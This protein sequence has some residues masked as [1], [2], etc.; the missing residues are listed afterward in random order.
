MAED[1]M[2]LREATYVALQQGGVELLNAP[3]RFMGTVLDL[4]DDGSVGARV[5]EQTCDAE[6]LAPYVEAARVRTPE[7]LD[8]AI[9]RASHVLTSDRFIQPD[10]AE[11][12]ANDLAWGLARYLGMAPTTRMQWEVVPAR[13]VEA[14]VRS[15]PVHAGTKYA[16]DPSAVRVTQTSTQ[17]VPHPAVSGA[18]AP[19]GVVPGTGWTSAPG[20]A[21]QYP[22]Q[23]AQA[24]PQPLTPQSD[25][26]EIIREAER[27]G[28]GMGWFRLVSGGLGKTLAVLEFLAALMLACVYTSAIMRAADHLAGGL[29][30]YSQIEPYEISETICLWL[31]CVT[32]ICR[33]IP[34]VR[35]SRFKRGAI[36]SYSA[37]SLLVSLGA[38]GFCAAYIACKLHQE[39]SPAFGY[40]VLPVVILYTFI[41]FWTSTYLRRREQFFIR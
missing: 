18:P 10:V 9:T 13:E 11:R 2:D 1:Q 32:T 23:A 28:F 6:L 19:S 20:M 37:C 35:L 3:Q 36:T 41:V 5:F 4:A 31:L 14:P 29:A 8:T 24:M 27:Q 25:P 7:A 40:S 38:V 15:R 22:V 26:K 17:V 39:T 33:L 30:R 21:G 12:E 16:D 34:L